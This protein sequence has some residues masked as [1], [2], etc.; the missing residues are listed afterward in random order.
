M[1]RVGHE[2]STCDAVRTSTVLRTRQQG[3][4]P[5]PDSK[6]TL[7][8]MSLIQKRGLRGLTVS[9]TCEDSVSPGRE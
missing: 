6:S 3:R 1:L 2:L 9:K 7:P 4:Q 5:V 8:V